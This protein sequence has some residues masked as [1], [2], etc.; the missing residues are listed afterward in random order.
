LGEDRCRGALHFPDDS[1]SELPNTTIA[2][3]I[4]MHVIEPGCATYYIDETLFTDDAMFRR[5]APEAVAREGPGRGGKG[6][7]TPH[8]D[9]SGTWHIERDIH[10][11]Q[12][13]P[14][15]PGCKPESG[16]GG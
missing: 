2:Q 10:L 14:G 7:T 4:H 5:M 8:R 3:H 15:Y 6:I 11:G 16:S 12:N 13:I 9:A 1:A